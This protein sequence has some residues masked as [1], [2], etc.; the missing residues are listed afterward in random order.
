MS[1]WDDDDAITA[2]K[3]FGRVVRVIP[4]TPSDN[5]SLLFLVFPRKGSLTPSSSSLSV[6]SSVSMWCGV[7]VLEK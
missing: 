5:R 1:N 2:T 6:L 7:N 4:K 3:T